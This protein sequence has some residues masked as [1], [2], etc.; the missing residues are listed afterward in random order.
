[1]SPELA[2][3]VEAAVTGRPAGRSKA[4]PKLTAVLRFGGVAAVIALVVWVALT[5]RQAIDEL[6]ADRKALLAQL[7]ED[8]SRATDADKAIVSRIEAWAGKHTG[9]YEGD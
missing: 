7:H 5:R 4:S 9:A 6:E 8:A 3:R 1:M 2:A